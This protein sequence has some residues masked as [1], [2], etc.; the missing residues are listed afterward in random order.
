MDPCVQRYL[1]GTER[2]EFRRPIRSR[3]GPRES[4]APLTGR[5]VELEVPRIGPGGRPWQMQQIPI[6][7][8]VRLRDVRRSTRSGR[9]P[10]DLVLLRQSVDAGLDRGEAVDAREAHIQQITLFSN[11]H[12]LEPRARARAAGASV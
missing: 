6:L 12:E 11:I 3:R 5:R 2:D 7:R 8:V 9:R 1:R 4:K 10:P